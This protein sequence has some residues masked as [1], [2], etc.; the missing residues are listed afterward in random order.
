[1]E[2]HNSDTL[3]KEEMNINTLDDAHEFCLS[4]NIV[5]TELLFP[6]LQLNDIY[7]EETIL[8]IKNDNLTNFVNSKNDK[9]PVKSAH[10]YNFNNELYNFF[11]YISELIFETDDINYIRNEFTKNSEILYNIINSKINLEDEKFY[12]NTKCSVP[13]DNTTE[14]ILNQLNDILE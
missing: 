9:L 2:N 11:M 8:D 10:N 5:N 14:Y 3:K 7:G 12:T 13:N 6:N 1:L 4:T